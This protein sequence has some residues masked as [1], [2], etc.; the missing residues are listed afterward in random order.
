M[1]KANKT[2]RSYFRLNKM[3]NERNAD[4]AFSQKNI[5]TM[6]IPNNS[7]VK[8]ILCRYDAGVVCGRCLKRCRPRWLCRNRKHFS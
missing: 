1:N 7:M 6:V 8:I 5:K 4:T 2:Y 3:E